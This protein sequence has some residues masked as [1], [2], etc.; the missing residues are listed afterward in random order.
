MKKNALAIVCMLSLLPALLTGCWHAESDPTDMERLPVAED[1]EPIDVPLALPLEFSLPYSAEQTL[2]P[3][4][5]PDG[6]QQTVGALLYEGLFALDEQWEPQKVLCSDYTYDPV[7]FTYTF[8]LRNDVTF[9]D[10]SPLTAADVAATLQ[11]AKTSPAIKPAS[12][13]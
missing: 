9:S 6:I 13:K 2:D 3:V 4:T 11:R 1:P 8:S 7:S 10:G 12:A 5:C